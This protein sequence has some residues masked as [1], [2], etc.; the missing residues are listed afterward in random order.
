VPEESVRTNPRSG[1]PIISPFDD[2]SFQTSWHRAFVRLPGRDILLS[3]A[4]IAAAT[5]KN[6]VSFFIVIAIFVDPF[7][8]EA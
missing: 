7:S 1:N 4:Q 6:A 3:I 5:A 2:V 8:A